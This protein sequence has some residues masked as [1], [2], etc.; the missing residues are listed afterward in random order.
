VLEY[1]DILQKV[2]GSVPNTHTHTHTHTHT[3]RDRD[4]ETDRDK[5]TYR[6]RDWHMYKYAQIQ[7]FWVESTHNYFYFISFDISQICSLVTQIL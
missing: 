7:F 3:Q 2:L 4:R 6:E 1:T 5:E